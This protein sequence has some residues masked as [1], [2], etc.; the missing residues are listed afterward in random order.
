M[1]IV[2]GVAGSAASNDFISSPTAHILWASIKLHGPHASCESPDQRCEC[3]WAINKQIKCQQQCGFMT[4]TLIHSLTHTHAPFLPGKLRA[5][6]TKFTMLFGNPANDLAHLRRWGLETNDAWHCPRW[7]KWSSE[8]SPS[9]TH[10]RAKRIDRQLNWERMPHSVQ[11]L[12]EGSQ[13]RA[14]WS[15]STSNDQ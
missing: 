10:S 11:W 6:T 1:A 9:W 8:R 15:H 3:G 2:C 13:K 7:R 5:R 4:T 14:N 12:S